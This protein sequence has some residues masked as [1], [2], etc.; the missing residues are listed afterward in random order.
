M[1]IQR[2][3]IMKRFFSFPCMV[4]FTLSKGKKQKLRI[5]LAKPTYKKKEVSYARFFWRERT[6]KA[7]W[8]TF[9]FRVP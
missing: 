4:S 1:V 5:L 7:A 2:M 6:L 9:F 8:V 3:T